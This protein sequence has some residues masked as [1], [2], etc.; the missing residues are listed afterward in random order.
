MSDAIDMLP[1]QTGAAA[2]ASDDKAMAIDT[3]PEL[4]ALL[5]EHCAEL[6]NNLCSEIQ[7]SAPAGTDFSGFT[8]RPQLTKDLNESFRRAVEEAG[9][10]HSIKSKCYFLPYQDTLN[11][12]ACA[13]AVAGGLVTL[14]NSGL[15]L[16]SVNYKYVSHVLENKG[17]TQYAISQNRLSPYNCAALN[18]RYWGCSREDVIG[19]DANK[20]I[21]FQNLWGVLSPPAQDTTGWH[22]FGNPNFQPPEYVEFDLVQ[23]LLTG[24][25][26]GQANN[27][28][29]LEKWAH[30]DHSNNCG[31]NSSGNERFSRCGPL[32]KSARNLAEA[33]NSVMQ[34]VHG[35]PE[36]NTPQYAEMVQSMYTVEDV[37][38][39][40]AAISYVINQNY[41]QACRE[42]SLCYGGRYNKVSARHAPAAELQKHVCYL[43]TPEQLAHA[44]KLQEMHAV[45]PQAGPFK[46]R[47][48]V[49][50]VQRTEQIERDYFTL[51]DFHPANNP[52]PWHSQKDVRLYN[53]AKRKG[54]RR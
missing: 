26:I 47:A 8:I 37:K 49:T 50:S 39:V 13:H 35:Y 18:A 48:Q 6:I 34:S 32:F 24:R 14:A 46:S 5:T 3:A 43:Q 31:S 30:Y 2:E 42:A 52:Y 4:Q 12:E 36:P 40:I 19:P 9:L 28:Y 38:R 10:Q 29:V 11:S 41:E 23:A 7:A 22:Q 45:A 44:L 53:S 25:N 20:S 21:P 1:A 27:P 17:S 15:G 51:T 16:K 33:W 54:N